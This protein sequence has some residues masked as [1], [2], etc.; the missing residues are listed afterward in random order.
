VAPQAMSGVAQ[1][2]MA[3]GVDR[4]DPFLGSRMASHA[5]HGVVGQYD[6]TRTRRASAPLSDRFTL[7]KRR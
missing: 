6:F 5:A 2:V 1:A 7:G 3:L 4:D